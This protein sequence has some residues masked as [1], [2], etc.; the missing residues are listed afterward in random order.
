MKKFFT[1]SFGLL[2][3]AFGANAT[4]YTYSYEFT[5]ANCANITADGTYDLGTDFQS[6]P[7]AWTIAT[8]P[9]DAAL[10]DFKFNTAGL[11]IGKN[12]MPAKQAVF[13]TS[14]IP[15]TIKEIKVY[16]GYASAVRYNVSIS[17]GG[18]TVLSAFAATKD[19]T[20]NPATATEISASG[21]IVIT[22]DSTTG[23]S[24]KGVMIINKIEITYDDGGSG[25]AVLQPYDHTF[26]DMHLA[27]YET[28]DIDMGSSAAPEGITFT[29]Q[30]PAVATVADGAVTGRKAGSTVVDAA[31]P[32]GSKY[33]AG[34][35]SFT[36]TVSA[37]EC[38]TFDFNASNYGLD[39]A[40]SC[41]NRVITLSVTGGSI[42]NNDKLGQVLSLTKNSG[43]ITIGWEHGYMHTI[44]FV[45]GNTA[46]LSATEGTFANP[47][48]KDDGKYL[49]SVSFAVGDGNVN[50]QKV[51]VIFSGDVT[52]GVENVASDS[53]CAREY[54]NLSGLRVEASD[55]TPGIYIVRQGD[56]VTKELVR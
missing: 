2:M 7:V 16:C 47:E 50:L 35:T 39:A 32:A 18:T 56:K 15:G 12:A 28:A 9:Q 49:N 46:K 5:E 3:C 53:T 10:P 21:K 24:D 22:F 30:D 8:T 38:V 13:S 4:E 1:L 41:S 14:G 31:W 40:T 45:G 37:S 17:V 52:T 43:G 44:K 55:L 6:N 25:P 29:P 51:H 42:K 26:A 23:A 20:A 34:S 54:Y 19:A 36:V 33:L 48:W 11:G 27:T